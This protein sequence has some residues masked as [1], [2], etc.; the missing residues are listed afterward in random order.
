[1]KILKIKEEGKL[2]C[3]NCEIGSITENEGNEKCTLC[4]KGKLFF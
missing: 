2:K 1:L 3:L 4:S